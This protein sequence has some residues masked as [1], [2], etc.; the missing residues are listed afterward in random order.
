[1]PL[2]LHGAN[3]CMPKQTTLPGAYAHG[4]GH[5]CITTTTVASY[6]SHQANVPYFLNQTPPSNS[7]CPQIGA[8]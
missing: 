8:S 3:A 7:S 5:N 6:I 2:S 4:S 1:M